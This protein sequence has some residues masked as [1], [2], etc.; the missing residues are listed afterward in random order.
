MALEHPR[1][2]NHH[3]VSRLLDHLDPV[4]RNGHELPG[5]GERDSPVALSPDNE[6]GAIYFG[7]TLE[8]HPAEPAPGPP[9]GDQL[10]HHSRKLR[11]R[12]PSREANQLRVK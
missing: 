2:L 6:R 11:A 1:L 10:T 4:V 3:Q 8:P 5:V 9:H 7:R 12:S